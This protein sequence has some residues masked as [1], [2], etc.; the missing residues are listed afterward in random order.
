[1][2][3]LDKFLI[4]I[5][6]INLFASIFIVFGKGKSDEIKTFE[7]GNFDEFV[8]TYM[9]G[10]SPERYRNF[11][12]ELV[13]S[14]FDKIYQDTKNL[15]DTE[16]KKYFDDNNSVTDMVPV[17]KMQS[18]YGI[19]DYTT[20]NNIVKQLREINEKKAEYKKCSI[21][22]KSCKMNSNYTTSEITLNYSKFQKINMTIEMSNLVQYD[23][24]M[25]KV[26]VKE[27]D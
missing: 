3:K 15:S 10:P 14:K 23:I 26:S 27:V 11:V 22:K 13:E 21:T 9:A 8:N 12:Q 4:L 19:S 24:Q 17:S 1:M 20:F 18:E 5:I 25:F 6:I 7:I 16:L 2:S